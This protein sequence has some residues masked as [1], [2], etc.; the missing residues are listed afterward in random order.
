[1]S[2][3]APRR[4]WGPRPFHLS[5]VA[6]GCQEAKD[7]QSWIVPVLRCPNG[8]QPCHCFHWPL[9]PAQRGL[10]EPTLCL[11]GELMDLRAHIASDLHQVGGQ[12]LFIPE[13]Q[14]SCHV[15]KRVLRKPRAVSMLLV[16][17]PCEKTIC[18]SS[19]RAQLPC[20]L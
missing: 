14:W 15:W 18:D 7:V 6:E 9:L 13:R 10:L 2:R 20:D 8:A 5:D 4:H 12:L 17:T 16:D 19:T 1:M 11:P 3:L